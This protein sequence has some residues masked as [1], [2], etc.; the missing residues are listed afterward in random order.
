MIYSPHIQQGT[1][2]KNNAF[3]AVLSLCMG[4]VLMAGIFNG[5]SLFSQ[6]VIAS[7]VPNITLLGSN[8]ITLS[9]GDVYTEPG[10][11]ATDSEDGDITGLVAVN[12]GGLNTAVA[13][14]YTITYSVID[15]DSNTT[16]NTRTVIVNAVNTAPTLFLAG[17][18]T[19]TLTVGDVYTEPG[20]T[21][22]D[23]ED[24][25]LT[26]SVSINDG[27]LNTAVAGTYTIT[28][29]VTDSGSLSDTATRTVVVNAV[30][31]PGNTAPVITLVGANPV[32]LTVGDVYTEPGYTATDTEDGDLTAS[33]SINDGGLN[34]AVA[35][36][37][38]ITYSVT[39]SGSLSDTATRT[40][41]VNAVPVTP[42][43]GGGG[44][45]STNHPPTL[46]LIG[47]EVV[48]VVG[49]PYVEPGFIADDIENGNLNNEVRINN[50]G[51][52]TDILGEYR[53]TYNVTDFNGLSAPQVTRLVKVVPGGGN[54][55]IQPTPPTPPIT[56][57][58]QCE[59]L[60]GFSRLGGVAPEN[61]PVEVRKV[62]HFLN[63]FEGANLAVDGVF[64]AN[65]D[66][67][68][69]AFQLKYRDDILDP[70][71]HTASTGYVYITTRQKINEIYCNRDFPLTVAQQNEITA[72]KAFLEEIIAN[73]PVNPTSPDETPN[74]SDILRG[75]Q[76]IIIFPEGIEVD[77][78]GNPLI[79]I[80][81][82]PGDGVP[83]EDDTGNLAS[84]LEA[85]RRFMEKGAINVYT[86][87]NIIFGAS[88]PTR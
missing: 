26:A 34:T 70:W 5:V 10:Y 18:T 58:Q 77:S 28:Y 27:G 55:P 24:G 31:A 11:I 74:I 39:D 36:T 69:R 8:P 50:G 25:D 45:G 3:Y 12:D 80:N 22:T 87:L 2:P 41:V 46:V 38:T 23:T 84:A 40:V 56:P 19:L 30:P 33:V 16:T 76:G 65:T 51:L 79:G 48:V 37:Y 85:V 35:G 67:A 68:V 78:E 20:Y 29:S 54:G 9:V 44:G 72:F 7:S 43:G 57:P 42:P 17:S 49:N 1:T 4:F 60:Y 53:L 15:A 64:D 88:G 73:T 71:G 66:A 59:Y 13:G 86:N 82:F 21:A 83:T 14:T 32:T 61:D 52:N 63:I 47:G 75:D 81:D 62:Q 6:E